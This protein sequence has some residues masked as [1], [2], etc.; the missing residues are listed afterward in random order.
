M[1]ESLI[2]SEITQPNQDSSITQLDKV[3]KEEPQ[4]E[5]DIE[6]DEAP[7][8]DIPQIRLEK[9]VTSTGPLGS[10]IFSALR[11]KEIEQPVIVVLGETGHGKSTF[12]NRMLH[13]PKD[14]DDNL[15]SVSAGVDACTYRTA[16]NQDNKFLA[17]D[18]YPLVTIIDTPG[19]GDPDGDF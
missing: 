4:S 9:V 7:K 16:V 6:E 19:F 5:E 12:C 8:R 2:D 15:F 1:N 11:K 13:K 10:S 3:D 18:K 14:L 17:N